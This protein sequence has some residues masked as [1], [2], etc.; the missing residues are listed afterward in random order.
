MIPRKP[1]HKR[2]ERSGKPMKRTRLRPVGKNSLQAQKRE[3][4]AEWKRD[5][6]HITW[7]ESCGIPDGFGDAKLTQMHAE[8]Q[9][10]ITTREGCRRAAKVCWGEHRAKD[11]ATGDDPHG[12]MAK[13]VDDL[14]ARR[15]D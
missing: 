1:H 9:R 6:A 2:L 12:E 7:C 13:F 11:E 10:F 3:W 14:I 4:N 5:F 15:P 8:K